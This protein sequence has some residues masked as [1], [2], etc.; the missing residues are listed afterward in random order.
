MGPTLTRGGERSPP[1][2]HRQKEPQGNAPL[3]AVTVQAT[4][5]PASRALE[6]ELALVQQDRAKLS[7][8]AALFSP[9]S[10]PPEAKRG[11]AVEGTLAALWRG[12]LGATSAPRT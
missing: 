9:L 8:L 12:A 2:V 4:R 11:R 10:A 5:P 3:Q 7:R 1:H 6:G